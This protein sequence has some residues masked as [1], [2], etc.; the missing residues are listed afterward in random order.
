M[1]IK[2]TG[3]SPARLIDGVGLCVRDVA[4]DVPEG[5]KDKLT[6]GLAEAS[7]SFTIVAAAPKT[8]AK[9]KPSSGGGE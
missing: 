8:A 9:P 4:K 5:L 3:P 6:A 7:D 2:Y 1:Q